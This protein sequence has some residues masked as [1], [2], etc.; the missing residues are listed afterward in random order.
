[1][2]TT[3]D[4]PNDSTQRI[5][6]EAGRRSGRA[7]I[8][9]TRITVADILSMLAAGMSTEDLLVEFPEL[10]RADIA[11]AL[12]HAATLEGMTRETGRAA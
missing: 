3:S 12:T 5:V 1:M 9:G 7:V 2:N 8:R 6:V 4:Q 11:A 10:G